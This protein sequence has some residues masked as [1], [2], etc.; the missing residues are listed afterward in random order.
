MESMRSAARN[1]AQGL[2]VTTGLV[3]HHVEFVPRQQPEDR[4]PRGIKGKSCRMRHPQVPAQCGLCRIKNALP[5][6]GQQVEEGKVLN[7]HALGPAGG[8]GREYDIGKIL[9]ASDGLASALSSLPS[10]HVTIRA[11][12]RTV[13]GTLV[14]GLLLG[15]LSIMAA[16][17][18]SRTGAASSSIPS[19]RP[20][21]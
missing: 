8:T 11:E 20:A 10:R 14:C 19:T 9:L 4:I 12:S 5:V 6:R 7:A 1:E 21:G 2:G 16:V 17:V 13:T 15:S 3:V 18:S